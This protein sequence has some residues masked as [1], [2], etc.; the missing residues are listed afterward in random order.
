MGI[1][2]WL[3]GGG[4]TVGKVVDGAGSALKG[5]GNWIDEKDF[6]PE[7]KSIA[8]GK[9]VDQHLALVKLTNEENSVRSITRRY[10][11]WLICLVSLFWGSVAMV[12]AILEK[13]TIVKG[14]VEV[15]SAFYLG[16]AFVSV[17]AFYFGVQFIRG[18]GK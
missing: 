7:E 18:A 9:A 8:L 4:D 2:S 5:I 14:M 12:F 3:M 13:A 10:L 16:I 15:S 17:V 11:A 1:L 6:T